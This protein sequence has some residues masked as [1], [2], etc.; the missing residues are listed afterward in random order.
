M[1]LFF[2]ARSWC[3]LVANFQ[4]QLCIFVTVLVKDGYTATQDITGMPELN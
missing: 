3:S 4:L 2:A 1:L